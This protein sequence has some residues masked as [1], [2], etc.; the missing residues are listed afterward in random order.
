M[1]DTLPTI[2]AGAVPSLLTLAVGRWLARVQKDRDAIS[3]AQA[4]QI[5]VLEMA[6]KKVEALEVKVAI[7]EERQSGM[8]ER[9]DGMKED[10]A[11]VREHMV[12]R[13]DLEALSVRIDDALR[14]TP[15]PRKPAK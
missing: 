1:S 12:R 3:A 14:R 4:K 2:A 10:L 6:A 8:S 9:I 13:A 7:L 5:E 11:D 15:M